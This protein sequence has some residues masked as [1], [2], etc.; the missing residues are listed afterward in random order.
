MNW[1]DLRFF[2]AAC[3][4]GSSSAAAR[5]LKVR[6]STVGRRLSALEGDLGVRL[7]VRT[8]TG[9]A[10]TEA[11]LAILAAAEEME[12]RAL[13][14]AQLAQSLGHGIEGKVRV[15]MS[16]AF[17]GYLFGK[18]PPLRDAHPLLQ[19]DIVAGNR[20]FDLQKGEADV[21][22]RMVPTEQPDLVS[23]VL[24]EASWSLYASRAYLQS[25]GRPPTPGDLAG[26]QVVGFD[27]S[28]AGS[29]GAMWLAANAAGAT[30]ALVG[31]S[32]GMVVQ[33]ADSGAGIAM[34]PCFLATARPNLVRLFD[35]LAEKRKI[36]LVFRRDVGEIARVRAVIDFISE[37]IRADR[38]LFIGS[39]ERL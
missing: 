9:F 13:D 16:E 28:L 31:N 12:R 21:A 30:V 33:A 22:V 32:V 29:P 15:T 36:W 39:E 7:F 38:A 2:L 6:H 4:E 34:I 24:G 23:R 8:G 20:T 17:A 35:D 10:V 25:A 19:V 11:G 1:D 3:R 27:D 5:R 26:H 18:L 37:T 14:I